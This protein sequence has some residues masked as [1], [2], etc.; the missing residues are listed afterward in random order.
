MNEE[1]CEC[2][3]QTSNSFLNNERFPDYDENNVDD[4]SCDCNEAVI[5]SEI[6]G[7]RVGCLSE[8]SAH[9][10]NEIAERNAKS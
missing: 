3:V 9:S 1:E 8:M 2:K 6:E 5:R 7:R 10:K 4:V